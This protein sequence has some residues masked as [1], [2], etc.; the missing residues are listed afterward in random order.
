MIVPKA[1]CQ[2]S[3]ML[4]PLGAFVT[5]LALAFGGALFCFRSLTLAAAAAATALATGEIELCSSMDG[6]PRVSCG[7]VMVDRA[8]AEAACRACLQCLLLLRGS[9]RLP[10]ETGCTGD[11]RGSRLLCHGFC[12]LCRLALHR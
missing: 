4:Y 5:V 1:S 2:Q 10:V 7:A 12:L 6:G 9:K 8:P 3:S 11:A